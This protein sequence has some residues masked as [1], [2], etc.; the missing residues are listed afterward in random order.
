[1]NFK[2]LY[3]SRILRILLLGALLAGV[4]WAVRGPPGTDQTIPEISVTLAEVAH[5]QAQWQRQWQRP[6]T[7][8]ELKKS[9]DGYVRN[10]ILYREALAR[11]LDREDPR[12]RLALIQKMQML[13][14]GRADAQEITEEDVAAFFA[15]RKEQYRIPA[16]LS[17]IQIYF[18]S[19]D[20]PEGARARVDNMREEFRLTEP[21]EATLA[22]VG[23]SIMLE[24]THLDVTASEL[25]KRLGT[26]FAAKV[27]PL[28]EHIWSG[29]IESSYGLHLVNVLN[30]TPG[31]VPELEEVRN[32]VVTDLR[33]ETRKVEEEQGYLE[34]AGK[35]RVVI[36]E[37]AEQILKGNQP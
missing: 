8:E 37:G 11:D 1:M 21:D 29:P 2:K 32:K 9:V 16:M 19:K 27:L 14:A 15:L 10:E 28:E 13:A 31:R 26:E 35:Y 33:Y 4:V 30:R 20:D 23:D 25:E 6:P 36:S 22:Q 7:A 5:L 34:V 3:S 17:V 18:K 12:V 24:K